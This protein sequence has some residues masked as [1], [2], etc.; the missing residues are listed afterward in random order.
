MPGRIDLKKEFKQLYTAGSR[1][2]ELI[3]VPPLGY[4]MID[5]AGNPNTVPAFQQAIEALYSVSYTLK[6]MLKK[7]PRAVDY[8][9]M[10]L[11]GLWW[12]DDMSRFSM[13]DKDSW[14][15]TAVILQPAF[16]TAKLV[17]EAVAQLKVKKK[18]LPALELVRLEQ[19]HEG[20]AA[21]VLH[22]G[23]YSAEAPAIE[24]L[25]A[26]IAAQGLRR[27]G[28]HH[29]IYMNDMRRVAPEKLRTFIRQ[30]VA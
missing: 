4:L 26:F 7:G 6:F 19:L 27:E 2:P 12:T 24:G 5:G 10:P 3:E 30:P 16:I 1:G 8:G 22:V 9:V 20:R 15:W 28:K 11:E 23:P 17:S 18:N 25:H 14:K 13:D 21:Q 29:E